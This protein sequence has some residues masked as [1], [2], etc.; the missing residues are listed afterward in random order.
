MDKKYSLG[1]DFGTESGRALLVNVETGE[2]VATSVYK[3]KNGVIDKTLPGTDIELKPDSALQDP[4]DYIKTLENTIPAVIKKSGIKPEQIIGIGTDFTSCTI[5]PTDK[6]GIPLCAYEKYRKNPHSWAKLWKHHAAQK[7]ANE[8]N[9]K[10]EQRNEEF[11]LIYGGKISSEWFFPKVME[12]LNDAPEIYK[13][14]DRIIEGADWIVWQLT[15]RETRTSCC[16][17]YKAIWEKDKGFPSSDFFKSL[18]PDLENVVS[19]KMSQEILPI[20]TKAGELTPAMAELTGLKPGT[21]VAV[22]IIDAH[23]A[24]PGTT[25]TAPGKMVMIMGTSTCHMLLSPEKKLV[26]GISGVVSDGIVPGYFGYEAG[27][28]ATGDIFGWFVK[29]CVP[30]NYKIEAENKNI[31][32]HSFL[33]KKAAK[34][35]VGESGLLALD[36]E[37]GCRSVLV[38]ADLSGLILG[39]T[40]QSKPEEIYRTLIEAT[41]FG[42]RIIIDAFEK[43][44]IKIHELYACGGLPEKNKLLIQIY[45]DVTN[46]EIK[47]AKSEL[48]GSLG[49]AMWGAVAAGKDNGGFNSIDDA[50]KN[51]AHLKNECYKPIPHNRD[52]YNRLYEEYKR[53]YNYFGRGENNIMKN[54]KSIKLKQ[55]EL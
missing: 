50:S 48:A 1:I 23:A 15:G 31:D 51:M 37:N 4:D 43:A 8:L 21:P 14:A 35:Q 36:W 49:A 39:L 26:E 13:A 12:I 41:A 5:L 27:Q 52:V 17:G 16:A 10:A 34:L 47:L 7:E 38:D 55:K 24:V 11:L 20:G 42:T 32:V 30:E 45:S 28:A 9:K 22:G 18:H 44:G 54:L 33:E 40:L 6:N 29:N 46:K 25:V 3:Y 53:L 2:E 19:E